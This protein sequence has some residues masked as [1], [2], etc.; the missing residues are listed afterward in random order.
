MAAIIDYITLGSKED[1]KSG[2]ILT[3]TRLPGLALDLGLMSLWRSEP[4]KKPIINPPSVFKQILNVPAVHL[5]RIL[6]PTS[7]QPRGTS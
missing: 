5:W 4:E 2:A 6:K 1:F 3:F 7:L